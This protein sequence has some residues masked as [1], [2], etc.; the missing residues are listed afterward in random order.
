[1]P[2]RMTL[3]LEY[4]SDAEVTAAM[5]AADAVVLPFRRVTT[6]GSALLALGHG[7]PVVV[8]ELEPLA[9][10][11]Q[12]AVVAYDGSVDGLSRAIA[13]LGAWTP[14]E[15]ARASAAAARYSQASG[16]AEAAR[17]THSALEHTRKRELVPA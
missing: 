1:M 3:R 11:P 16:W 4:V 17:L 12:D 14:D 2:G 8:P 9:G 13:L 7:R 10:L 6:S 15:F 5:E